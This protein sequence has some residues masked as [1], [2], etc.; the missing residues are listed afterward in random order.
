MSQMPICRKKGAGQPAGA[1]T[2][3]GP[4][5]ITIPTLPCR[6]SQKELQNSLAVLINHSAKTGLNKLSN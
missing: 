3:Q 4:L 5:A 2:D 1:R 6:K